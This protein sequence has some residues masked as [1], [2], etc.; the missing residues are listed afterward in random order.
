MGSQVALAQIERVEQ[1]IRER[2]EQFEERE[3]ALRER[4][5]E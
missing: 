2:A 1:D 3:T 5:A 4:F